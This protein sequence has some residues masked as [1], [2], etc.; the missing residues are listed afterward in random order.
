MKWSRLIGLV[1]VLGA[2]D[3]VIAADI[4]YTVTRQQSGVTKRYS[5][6]LFD[7][8]SNADAYH[9]APGQRFIAAEL[10]GPGEIRHIWFTVAGQ[11]RRWPRSLVL[12]IY[13]D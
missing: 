4:L 11:D 12:R 13:W 6:G 5:S 2:L 1:A 8:E 9:L 7:P 10:D 3:G